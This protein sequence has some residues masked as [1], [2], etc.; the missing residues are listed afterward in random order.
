MKNSAWKLRRLTIL[1]MLVSLA[2]LSVF[3]T[4]IPIVPGA[5]FLTYEPK[6]AL[7]TIGAFLLDP[8]AG[9]VMTVAVAFLEFISFS[10]TGAIGL[11]MNIFSS[12][13]FVCTASL[14]YRRKRTLPGAIV[15]LLCAVVLATA[16]MVL[17]NY[18]LTPLYMKVPRDLV[19]TMIP[20]IF[21]PFNLIKSA[22]NATI[23]MLLYKSVASA[24]RS[25]K[26]LPPA[27][28]QKKANSYIPVIVLSAFILIG[29]SL[30]LFAW[31]GII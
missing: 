1:G 27:T 17:W 5:G 10:D 31:N 12:C 9:V 28:V 20:T 4:R 11:A 16:G 8:L 19:V 18:L 29:I 2:Y 3:I 30:A 22:L 21:L 13:L 6:D 24:L 15:G 25:A 26:L 14:I 7:I 23:T